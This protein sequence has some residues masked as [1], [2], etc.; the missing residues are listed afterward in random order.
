MRAILELLQHKL[1]GIE[2]WIFSVRTKVRK[3][4]IAD[5]PSNASRGKHIDVKLHYTRGLIRAGNVRV[6]HMGT[7]EQPTNVLTNPLWIKTFLLHRGDSC[8]HLEVVLGAQGLP[9]LTEYL[10][11][12]E[13]LC[14]STSSNHR[15]SSTI[16]SLEG[17]VCLVSRLIETFA[18]IEDCH[19]PLPTQ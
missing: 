12:I 19:L 7:E 9:F 4:S 1:N 6:M 14:V 16:A 3:R 5:Q 13:S 17:L 10:L 8:I 15:E 2:I 18:A 11:L